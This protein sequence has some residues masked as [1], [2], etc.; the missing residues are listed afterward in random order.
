VGVQGDH[1]HVKRNVFGF[2]YP[3]SWLMSSFSIGNLAVI[4]SIKSSPD[5]IPDFAP[6]GNTK[7]ATCV[8]NAGGFLQTERK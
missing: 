7:R 6:F 2:T 8:V 1:V 5:S 3:S 4:L